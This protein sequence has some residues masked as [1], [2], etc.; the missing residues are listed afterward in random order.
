M[1][2]HVILTIGKNLSA[3]RCPALPINEML[4]L[5]QACVGQLRGWYLCRASHII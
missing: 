2:S 1:N 4:H 5:R 3:A